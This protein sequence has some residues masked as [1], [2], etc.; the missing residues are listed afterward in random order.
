MILKSSQHKIQV[1]PLRREEAAV[2]R[3]GGGGGG[4]S[5]HRA[6]QAAGAR[7]GAHVAGAGWECVPITPQASVGILVLSL[8]TRPQISL[9]RMRR[10]GDDLV[11]GRRG[12]GPVKGGNSGEA[13]RGLVLTWPE[14]AV[15]WTDGPSAPSLP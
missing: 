14:V 9:K 3:V 15:Q 12:T 7:G 1:K 11:T 6:P 13:I 8:G 4:G 5:L 10:S 2:Y